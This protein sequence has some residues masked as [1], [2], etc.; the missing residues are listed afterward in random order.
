MRLPLI[1]VNCKATKGAV[2]ADAVRL[3]KQCQAVA[4]QTGASIA[5]AV[6]AIDLPAVAKAVSIP[7]LVEHVASVG[8]GSY[9]GHLP[10]ALAKMHGAKG[11]LLNHSE[12]RLPKSIL[13]ASIKAAHDA[14]LWVCACANT[15]ADARNVAALGPDV[16]A[17]EPPELIGG[18]VSVSKAKPGILTATTSRIKHIPVLC[19]AGVKTTED[20]AIA[21]KLGTKGIL[22]ASGVTLAKN[23][24]KALRDLVNGL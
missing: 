17:I 24:A 16:V 3:A 20:V 12:H 11:T 6:Q 21:R 8:F 1:I 15:P 9:T 10:A 19:G 4:R 2:G 5:I 18:N 23:P 22:V 14:G 13:R 7:V